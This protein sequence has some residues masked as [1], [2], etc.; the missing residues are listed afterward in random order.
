MEQ[1]LKELEE[2][3]ASMQRAEKQVQQKEL[4][5]RERRSARLEEVSLDD[6]P[7]IIT[8][9]VCMYSLY[10][11]FQSQIQHNFKAIICLLSIYTHAH[12]HITQLTQY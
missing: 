12:I 9:N 4:E 7:A 3:V 8:L 10:I 1:R 5:E 11:L 2:R 6:K